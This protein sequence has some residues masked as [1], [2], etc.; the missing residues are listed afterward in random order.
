VE[1]SEPDLTGREELPV[2]DAHGTADP[3]IPID[4]GRATRDLLEGR[5]DLTYRE[6]PGGHTIDPRAFDEM[7]EFVAAAVPE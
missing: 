1:G 3:I 5:L 2:Y 6:H 4:F 7:R